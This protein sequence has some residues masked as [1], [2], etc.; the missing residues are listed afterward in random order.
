LFVRIDNKFALLYHYDMSIINTDMVKKIIKT[1]FTDKEALV[2]VSLL[3]LGGAYPSR[4]AEYTGLNRSTA[5]KILLQL[6][7]RGVIS[8]IEKR[9][10]IYYQI[11]K[12]EKISQH[13]E[14]RVN[15]AVNELSY[16]KEVIP[17][18]AGLFNT[19]KNHPRVT[20]YEGADGLQSIY[21]DIVS[22]KKPYEMLAF[23]KTDDFVNLLSEKFLIDFVKKKVEIG[24]TTRGLLP[25]TKDSRRFVAQYYSKEVPDKFQPKSRYVN[26]DAFPLNGEIIMYGDSRISMTNFSQNQVTGIIIDDKALHQ[27]MR[28]IF[29]LSWS[30]PQLKD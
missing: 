27:M 13:A 9:N 4:I 1:G 22:I 7:V 10:K 14:R 12:P 20:Y 5:Y 23:S 2:Y 18:I 15:M 24:I 19:L 17:E 25:D 28:V 3:E 6:S 21:E 8:E 11:E 30:S 29:E 26:P 16:T